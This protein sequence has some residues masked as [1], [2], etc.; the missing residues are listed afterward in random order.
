MASMQ[1]REFRSVVKNTL[2]GFATVE[3]PSGLVIY[4]IPVHTKGGKS[5]AS[6]PSAPQI[7]NGAVRV[8][9]GKA[10]YK[11]ILEWRDRDLQDRFSTALCD[12]I[13]THNPNVLR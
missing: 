8:K 3:L 5:W 11:R 13:T 6:M 2:R 1:L 7:E 9:D 10:Q 4:D 12:L